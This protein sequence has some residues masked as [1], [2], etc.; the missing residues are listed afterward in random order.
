MGKPY[1]VSASL[2]VYVTAP[3]EELALE[4]LVKKTDRLMYSEKA[5]KK[6]MYANN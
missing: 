3:D 6:A 2:G 1:E 5:R 4:E